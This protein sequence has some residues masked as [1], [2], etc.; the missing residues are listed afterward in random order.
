MKTTPMDWAWGLFPAPEGGGERLDVEA[1]VRHATALLEADEDAGER[2][3][4]GDVLHWAH[5]LKTEQS[6]AGDWPAHV[7]ARTGEADGPA[8]TLAPAGLMRRL[9]GMLHSTEFT[10]CIAR[11]GR[12]GAPA[13]KELTPCTRTISTPHR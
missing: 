7:N 4:T 10:D 5:H 13:P 9:E 12:T 3:R 8:R 1:L 11:A 2:T 6:E